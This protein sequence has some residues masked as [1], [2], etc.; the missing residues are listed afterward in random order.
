VH[1]DRKKANSW[2]YSA[3][4][5]RYLNG[6][7]ITNRSDGY[8]ASISGYFQTKK[9]NIDP[10]ALWD[11]APHVYNAALSKLNEKVRGTLDLSTALAQAG[12]TTRMFGATDKLEL[13]AK[14]KLGGKSS[15]SAI[16]SAW[17]EFQYGWRPLVDDIYGSLDEATNLILNEIER[18]K[19]RS[20]DTVTYSSNVS[21]PTPV[22][23]FNGRPVHKG[24]HVCEFG[25]R[26]KTKGHNLDRWI[27]LNPITI[28]WELIPYSFIVDWFF[29]VGGY[30]RDLETSLLYGNSFVDGYC[31]QGT[32]TD[33]TYKG[34]FG[35]AE[36]IGVASSSLKYRYLNRVK[37]SSYPCP[38][39]P[40]FKVD[41]GSQRLLNAAALLG[42]LLKR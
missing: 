2:S 20:Q 17:L 40:S 29:N 35:N 26:F 5:R 14:L 6:Y 38:R 1:G 42:V 33:S 30:I 4:H 13:F 23:V 34:S 41:L 27:S 22:G 8:T 3:Y 28:A 21:V 15:I 7:V 18:V 39:L 11:N 37:L 32:F 25:L 16:S 10:C 24:L 19:A 9:D 31:T 12:Q 36:T